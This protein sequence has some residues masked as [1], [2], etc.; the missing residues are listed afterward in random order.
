MPPREKGEP[1]C[2]NVQYNY[3]HL[4]FNYFCRHIHVQVC[5]LQKR[6]ASI[7]KELKE[8]REDNI[9]LKCKEDAE[10]KIK[11]ETTKDMVARWNIDKQ[12]CSKDAAK[13]K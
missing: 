8:E 10:M 1:T 5:H 2:A 9:I 12:G 11:K 4:Q 7:E 3:Y 6:L 13:K